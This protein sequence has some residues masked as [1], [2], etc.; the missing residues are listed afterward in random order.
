MEPKPA[1]A[2]K[3]KP[4]QELETVVVRFAG[5]SGDGMQ[6]A[7]GQFTT[8]SA[9]VGNDVSTLPD[10]PAEIRAPAGTL[11][12]VSGFQVCFSKRDILTPGDEIDTLIAMNPAALKSNIKDLKRG[13]ILIVDTDYFGDADLQ[14]AGYKTNPL[15]DGSLN[16]YQ[17]VKIPITTM[18][19][20][21]IGQMPGL[22]LKEVDRCRNVFA[23]GLVYWLYERPM[24]PTLRG[25]KEKL[26]KKN[27]VLVEAN[28]KTLNAGYNFG[29]TTEAIAVHYRVPKATVHRPGRYRQ[30]QGYEAVV[31]GLITAA[32]LAGK[33]VVYASYPITPASTMLHE[34]ASHKNFD[35][36][37]LQMEDEIAAIGAAIGASFGGAFGVTGTSGPG[38]ALKSEAI[39]LAVITELPLLVIDVQRGGPSTGLPTKTEQADLLQAM[40]GRNGECPV[41][42]IAPATPAD[43]FPMIQEAFRIAVQ[44]MTP[45]LF[46]SDGYIANGAEPWQIPD[47]S[48]LRRI[49][50]QHATAPHGNGT[51]FLPYKRDDRLVRPWALPGTPGLE[52]R[53]GGLEKQDVTGNVS[54][55]P[56]NHQHMVHTRAA[57]IAGIAN[58]I[59]QQEVHGD[60][61]GDLLVVGWGGTYGAIT[62]AVDE[63]RA[64]GRK[65]SAI[66]IRY[67]NPFPRNLGDLLKRFRKVL[68]AE[69]NLGQLRMLIRDRFLVDA[70]G[71][72]KIAGQP[73]M[74]REITTKI[75][76]LLK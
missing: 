23:L 41:A 76:E 45:V 31:Y 14:K 61:E 18:N 1:P 11:A 30:I 20:D 39:G 12:G 5:D 53:I 8:V 66:H 75:D 13:G 32:K 7:G 4:V 63:A 28:T 34:L 24:E 65:V 72:N 33:R 37:T 68:V 62:T 73:F 57:K 29:D 17:V 49:Q 2:A 36:L 26:G 9:I 43:C 16:A 71:L 44:Y 67:L 10:Y 74:V 52:H 48:T 40:F 25:I 42:V 70:I 69:L 60:S 47:P 22:T 58:D 55:D 46:L 50:V 54:Y 27:P 19:R 35:V 59:P 38:L 64:K 15:E 6:T 56:A 21:A 3:G 51:G